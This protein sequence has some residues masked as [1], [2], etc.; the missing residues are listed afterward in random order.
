MTAHT[1]GERVEQIRAQANCEKLKQK[2]NR[3][4]RRDRQDQ[5]DRLVHLKVVWKD[6]VFAGNEVLRVPRSEHMLRFITL[7]LERVLYEQRW[8]FVRGRDMSLVLQRLNTQ[9]S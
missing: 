6:F 4:E 7:Q 8:S 3:L 1:P 5:R 9:V 2:E